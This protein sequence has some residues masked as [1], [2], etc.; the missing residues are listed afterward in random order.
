MK[1]IVALLFSIYVRTHNLGYDSTFNHVALSLFYSLKISPFGTIAELVGG[2]LPIIL[3]WIGV[4]WLIKRFRPQKSSHTNVTFKQSSLP[5]RLFNRKHETTDQS[6]LLDTQNT[7]RDPTATENLIKYGPWVFSAI[8]IIVLLSSI[9]QFDRDSKK[10]NV[11]SVPTTSPATIATQKPIE[12]AAQQTPTNVDEFVTLKKESDPLSPNHPTNYFSIKNLDATPKDQLRSRY[13]YWM[14]TYASEFLTE[15]GIQQYKQ[16]ASRHPNGFG[17]TECIGFWDF[18]GESTDIDFYI[19]RCTIK[20]LGKYRATWSLINYKIPQKNNNEEYFLSVKSRIIF[21][22]TNERSA[23]MGAFYYSKPMGVGKLV[24]SH[25][26]KEN[27]WD[28]RDV[29]PNSVAAV[30]LRDTCNLLAPR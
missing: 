30:E 23:I 1:Y 13:E 28:F 9:F 22:C 15:T 4:E 16:E 20:S 12:T 8:C 3:I 10:T 18:T 2:M 21:D 6:Q 17:L 19:D 29:T 5:V 25:N 7:S 26:W 11:V 27:E 14:K 24:K